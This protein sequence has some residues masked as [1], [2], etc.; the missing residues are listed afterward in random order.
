MACQQF[1]R[2]EGAV[3]EMKRF[4]LLSLCLFA[5]ISS[6]LHCQVVLA[7]GSLPDLQQAMKISSESG[8]PILR[9]LV[10]APQS[11]FASSSATETRLCD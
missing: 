2:R 1:A 4:L 11:P 6:A 9:W 8:R 5:A 7:Q 3:F 10:R